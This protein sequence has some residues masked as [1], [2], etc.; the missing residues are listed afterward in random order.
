MIQ[1]F[2]S[3]VNFGPG[4]VFDNLTAGL[5]KIRVDYQVNPLQL[6]SS[7]PSYCL[8]PHPILFND[9]SSMSIGPNICVLPTDLEVVMEQKFKYF[10]TPCSWTKELCSRWIDPDKIKVWPVGIDLDKFNPFNSQKEI[11]CL[12]YLKNRTNEEL[13]VVKKI[14]SKFNQSYTILEYGKYSEEEFLE[15]I[16]TSKYSFILGNTE[17]QGIAIQEMMSCNLPLFVWDKTEWDHRGEEFKC[18]ASTVPYWDKICGIKAGTNIEE[19]FE[20]FLDTIGDYNPRSY[21]EN[22]FSL[23]KRAS[24]F[25][26]IR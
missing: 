14:L 22:N 25:L 8:S 4:K 9:S 16:S 21:I 15:K 7:T 20:K 17:S 24:E 10:I 26:T 11:D 23:E 6:N 19:N 2:I 18:A 3:N 12:L 5:R 13:D 1:L